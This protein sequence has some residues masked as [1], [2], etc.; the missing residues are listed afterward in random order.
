MRDLSVV[1]MLIGISACSSQPAATAPPPA[2]V[3]SKP[4]TSAPASPTAS[5]TRPPF[6]QSPWSPGAQ[7]STW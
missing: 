5:T 2:S 3:D 6:S 7:T 1:A 4:A